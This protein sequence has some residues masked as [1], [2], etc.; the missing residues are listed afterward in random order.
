MEMNVGRTS[1]TIIIPARLK[2]VVITTPTR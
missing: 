1:N 2:A